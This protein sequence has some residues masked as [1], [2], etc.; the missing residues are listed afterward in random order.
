[1]R[2][3]MSLMIRSNV[4]KKYLV[5]K[6]RFRVEQPEDPFLPFLSRLFSELDPFSKKLECSMYRIGI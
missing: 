2:G 6:S 5:L 3:F 4:I 1:M